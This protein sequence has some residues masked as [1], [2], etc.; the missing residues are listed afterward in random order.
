[1]NLNTNLELMNEKCCPGVV[2]SNSFSYLN[3]TEMT[4]MP[5]SGILKKDGNKHKWDTA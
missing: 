2:S 1:M 3:N 4:I 5:P